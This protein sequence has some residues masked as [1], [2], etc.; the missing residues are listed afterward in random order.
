MFCSKC[1]ATVPEGVS[2]CPACGQPTGGAATAMPPAPSPGIAA[3]YAAAMATPP[4]PYAG[5]WL[6]FLAAILDALVLGIPVACIAVLAIALGF[7]AGFH[8]INPDDPPTAIIAAM[9]GFILLFVVA[10]AVGEWLYFALLEASSWQGTVGKKILGLYVTDVEGKRVSFG[11]ASG[12]FC[13]GRLM[14]FVPGIGGLYFLVSCI[15]AGF[16]E[17][18]QA[19][20][21][22]IAGCLV[23]KKV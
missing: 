3:A 4:P 8:N 11:R 13:G 20:H 23:M 22:M 5:F 10:F 18:K 16:T 12:R 15:C 19:L 21:D 14:R 17:K 7:G 2:F 9:I 1:G 6:R